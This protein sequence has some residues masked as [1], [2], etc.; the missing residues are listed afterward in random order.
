M[1]K[2][3][4]ICGKE[5]DDYDWN[6]DNKAY[7]DHT[8]K[9]I[10]PDCENELWDNEEEGIFISTCAE[11]GKEIDYFEEYH[12]FCNETDG[13]VDNHQII[14]SEYIGYCKE[15]AYHKAHD[16]NLELDDEYDEIFGSND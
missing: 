12:E 3:C 13:Y 4:E 1:P 16:D 2:I 14:E 9:D 6:F 10:C 11:C 15:C 7:Y 5:Y 8:T